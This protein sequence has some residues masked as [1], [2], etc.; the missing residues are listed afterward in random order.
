MSEF[1]NWGNSPKEE[2]TMLHITGSMKTLK[3]ELWSARNVLKDII[4]VLKS[5]NSD[6]NLTKEVGIFV[7]Q[8]PDYKILN[9][10]ADTAKQILRKVCTG[11]LSCS[12]AS[13]KFR[14]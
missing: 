2:A 12:E 8:M 6:I 14:V 5:A 11:E 1:N 13:S 3:G 4:G 10:D 7:I 9:K